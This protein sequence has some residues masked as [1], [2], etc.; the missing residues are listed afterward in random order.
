MDLQ[1][2]PLLDEDGRGYEGILPVIKI[3]ADDD[4]DD[5]RDPRGKEVPIDSS[6]SF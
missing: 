6:S 2:F 4:A 5:G 3:P 1:L